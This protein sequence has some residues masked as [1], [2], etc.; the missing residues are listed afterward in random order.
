[1]PA[2]FMSQQG[3]DRV[4]IDKTI[5]TGGHDATALAG[6]GQQQCA[7]RLLWPTLDTAARGMPWWSVPIGSE[8][9]F[10]AAL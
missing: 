8:I 7:T 2:Y 10:P 5:Y 4:V 1:M 3:V 9:T 6:P